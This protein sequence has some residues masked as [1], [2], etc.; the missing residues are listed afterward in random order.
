MATLTCAW[1][2]ASFER[3][4]ATVKYRLKKGQT[5]FLCSRNCNGH[6]SPRG[7]RKERLVP[8]AYRQITLEDGRL[9]IEHRHLAEVRLGRPL[10]K[11][12]R[13]HH[14]DEIKTNNSIDNLE[15][16]THQQHQIEHARRKV[17]RY[18]TK[19]LE[20]R[21]SGLSFRAIAKELGLAKGD[22]IRNALLKYADGKGCAER[23]NKAK[24][25]KIIC[26]TCGVLVIKKESDI[27]YRRRQ[28]QTKFF[29]DSRCS[30]IYASNK[31]WST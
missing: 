7:I 3:S 14:I 27:L 24:I 17:A 11:N 15:V 9:V 6:F 29:C 10:Q 8:E 26:A 23:S 21:N 19:A 13:V 4:D 16:L 20:L 2:K 28:G 25:L 30:N 22:T 5:A 31:R 1:C 12:E 18:L